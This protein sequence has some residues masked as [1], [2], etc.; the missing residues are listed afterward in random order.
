M[1]T[2]GRFSWG[3]FFAGAIA[4]LVLVIIAAAAIVFGGLYPVGVTTPHTKAVSALIGA[5]RDNGVA[6]A[7]SGIT[8]PTLSQADI[9]EGGSHFKGMCEECHGGPGV[10]PEDFATA[11]Y[12]APPDL[13]KET[14]DLSLA[15]V[16]WIVKNGLKMSAMP[17]FGK[18]R[19]DQEL[20]E[21]AWFV[22]NMSKVDPSQYAALPNARA[23]EIK[24]GEKP[25]SEADHD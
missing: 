12:P 11:I 20:W 21:I 9:F 13:A 22:K 19:R 5:A 2:T 1:A 24:E 6:R 23:R 25:A 16:F 17:A 18:Y 10:R 3:A 7:A 15:E 14:D 8:P 4:L